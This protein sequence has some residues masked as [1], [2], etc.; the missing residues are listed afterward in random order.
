MRES[1]FLERC[2]SSAVRKR[3]E[4]E[5]KERGERRVG[6]YLMI[7][8]LAEGTHLEQ[9]IKATSNEDRIRYILEHSELIESSDGEEGINIVWCPTSQVITHRVLSPRLRKEL[10][11]KH[12]LQT[13]VRHLPP[14]EKQNLRKSMKNLLEVRVEKRLQAKRQ[15]CLDLELDLDELTAMPPLFL[16]S[17]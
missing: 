14:Y 13:W 2:A 1:V 10:G 6:N 12:Y 16:Q 15:G 8:Y 17:R 4:R 3:E 5:A 11:G 7:G 9:A